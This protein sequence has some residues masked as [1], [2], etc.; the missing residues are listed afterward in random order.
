MKPTP[1]MP[2]SEARRE[3]P[4]CAEQIKAAA[5]I[6]PFCQ[7]RLGRHARPQQEL[8][9]GVLLVVWTVLI[10]GFI[11]WE[12]RL[13][14]PK[15]GRDTTAY[16]QELQVTRVQLSASDS[17]SAALT[18][19]ITNQGRRFWWVHSLEVRFLNPD[20]NLLDVRAPTMPESFVAP[21]GQ[22]TAFRV[23]L[24]GLP[25]AVLAAG[26]QARVNEASVGQSRHLSED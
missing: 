4:F 9:A 24:K 2:S 1:D 15:S 17:R 7:S 18:G 11:F 6:C 25:E 22:E 3:C 10:A 23:T 21:P 14:W 19:W 16:R 20:G 13:T 26:I 12:K 5:K 8:Q